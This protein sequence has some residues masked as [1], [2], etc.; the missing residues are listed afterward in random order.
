MKLIADLHT[1]TCASTHAFSTLHE[2]Q[3][4]AQKIGLQA[5][6]ITDHAVA[7]DDSPHI[8]HFHTITRL[9]TL[10]PGNFLLLKGAEVNVLDTK[11]TLDLDE[12]IL[13]KLDWVVA[14]I[15]QVCVE[16]LHYQQATEAW[17]AIA[18]NP[19]VD[20]IG[21]SEEGRY[22]Y[23]YDLVTQEFS[24]TGKVVEMNA[25]SCVARP[26]NEE[27]QRQLAL[28][29]KKNGTHIAINSDAHSL[30]ELG[31]WQP[32]ISMLEE[33]DFPPELIVNTSMKRLIRVLESHGRDAARRIYELGYVGEA[34][35]QD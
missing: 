1:H 11:G 17:L 10:L 2:M 21:H 3:Q 34:D 6:A 26:G 32:I 27:N 14:S 20:M 8:S 30:Y 5:L 22:L 12:K 19:Y 28:A 25:S 18:Q 24:K 35:E 15:H 31:N 7:V 13:K 4:Q 16:P 23:D 9:P 33:I 29:C